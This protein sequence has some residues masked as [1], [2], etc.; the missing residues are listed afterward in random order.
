LIL[1]TPR[2]AIF[3]NKPRVT[4]NPSGCLSSTASSGHP[5]P[6]R[7]G[8]TIEFPRHYQRLFPKIISV[9]L[10]CLNHSTRSSR[11]VLAPLDV[12]TSRVRL[13]TLSLFAFGFLQIWLAGNCL[14]RSKRT[15]RRRN[16]RRTLIY[17][18]ARLRKNRG[19]QGV[20][21]FSLHTRDLVVG[22]S[23]ELGGF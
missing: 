22:L 13:I 2:S 16:L 9:Q 11:K 23:S 17:S 19:M 15:G 6:D 21:S 7:T 1:Q 5:R 8:T 4:Y 18:I 3:T 14:R 10:S 20:R 12:K